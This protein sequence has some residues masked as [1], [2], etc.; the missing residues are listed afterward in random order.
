MNLSELRSAEEGNKRAELTNRR[1][2]L[3]QTIGNL[4]IIT[5]SL[6][7]SVQNKSWNVKKPELQKHSLLPINQRLWDIDEWNEETIESRSKELF[8]LAKQIWRS[9]KINSPNL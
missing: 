7:S 3:L 9:P 4:T 8:N 2:S 5:G 6:N 1:N